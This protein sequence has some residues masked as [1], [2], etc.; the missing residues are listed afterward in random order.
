MKW[1]WRKPPAPRADLVRIAVLEF[2]LFGIEPK[3]GTLAAALVGLNQFSGAMAH[4]VIT[5]PPGTPR[6]E[7]DLFRAV[8]ERHDAYSFPFQ[9]ADGT[10][11]IVRQ[12]PSA[13]HLDRPGNLG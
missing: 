7:M 6:R 4:A 11:E 12:D 1:P 5:F 8:W 9:K 13:A 2:E 3:P 10:I